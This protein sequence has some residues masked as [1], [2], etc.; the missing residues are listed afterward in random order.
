[1]RFNE[2]EHIISGIHNYCDR[3]C[4][5]C[6]LSS[7]CTIYDGSHDADKEDFVTQLANT[8]AETMLMLEQIMKEHGVPMLTPEE[9]KTFEEK[10]ER[11]R[12]EVKKHPL[13]KASFEYI[14]LIKNWDKK[15]QSELE[16]FTAEMLSS[17]EMGI[18]KEESA[19]T[20]LNEVGECIEIY[21]WYLYLIN[22][23]FSRA[24]NGKIHEAEDD[25][26]DDYP[27]DSD[28]S[29]KVALLAAERSLQTWVKL[30]QIFPH[31]SDAMLPLMAKLQQ[32]IKLA[33]TEF[34]NAR[35]FVRPGFDENI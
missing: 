22:V 2:G 24:L 10:E 12:L 11:N 16:A 26:E 19:A 13:H 23:K 21:R 29:A 18:E 35:A 6:T 31:L 7:R 34:P 14:G 4:E 25:D 9:N 15:H 5:R 8:F 28:G 32:C 1:M 3:W 27:K 20:K 30:Y 17:L 33:D